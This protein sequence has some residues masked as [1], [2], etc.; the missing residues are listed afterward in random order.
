VFAEWDLEES[1]QDGTT[2]HL[3]GMTAMTIERARGKFVQDY[4]FEHEVMAEISRKATARADL[5]PL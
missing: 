1:D 4:I 2:C 3:S 5:A